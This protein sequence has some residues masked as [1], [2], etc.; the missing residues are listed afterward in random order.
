M[1]PLLPLLLATQ[2]YHGFVQRDL[3]VDGLNAIL[4]EPQKPRKDHAWI[5]RME[6]FDH[7]PELDLALLNRGF[8]LA[9]IEVGNTH[10]SP[11][12]MEQCSTFYRM[13]TNTYGLSKKPVL[14]GFSRGGLYGYNWAVRNPDKVAAIYGDAPVCDFT[15][16]PYGGRGGKRSDSDWNEIID[17]YGFPSEKAALEY[18]FQPIANL[19]PL[20]LAHIPI[21]HVVGDKDVVVP[22]TEN[23]GV[24]EA[25]YKKYGGTIQIIHKPEGDH[26]P[27]SLDD[28]TPIVDFLMRHLNDTAKT[29][30]ATVI[31]APNPE[32][33]Y[34]SAGWNG[35]SWMDQ[36]LD[37][38]KA[39][40]SESAEVVLLG[41]SITQGW[42]GPGRQVAA[43]GAAAFLR[44]FKGWRTVGMGMSGDRTQNVLWRLKRGILREVQPKAVVVAIGINNWNNDS[45]DAVVLGIE[46][47]IKEIHAQ[48][49]KAKVLITGLFPTG[50]SDRDPR[51]TYVGDVNRRLERIKS[52]SFVDV[53]RK[54]LTPGGETDFTKMAD[55][56]LH[57][58][59]G[60]YEVWGEALRA[61][62]IRLGV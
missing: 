24:L 32:S 29:E 39:A 31:P 2:T 19:E 14:E 10:G 34:G 13:L 38:E 60:G 23:T 46:R 6:F 3:K 1:F 40:R 37:S 43:P 36:V 4:V 52:V 35:R 16:W 15:T 56:S 18:P 57:L 47:I 53:G 58:A 30:P 41:D 59:P 48:A 22:M 12:A 62:L 42:G 26:H 7:R 5:W 11:A 61:E 50:F 51:R 44:T 55:D 8:F 21:I 25:R 33:R 9:Y 54:L 20:A 17:Q 45:V 27:H 28:P 49:P